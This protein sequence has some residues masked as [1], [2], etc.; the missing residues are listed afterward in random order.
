M[1]VDL[2]ALCLQLRLGYLLKE[3]RFPALPFHHLAFEAQQQG[4]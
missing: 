2:R 4:D 3:H 1:R